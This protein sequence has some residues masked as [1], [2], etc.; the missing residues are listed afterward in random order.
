MMYSGSS[1]SLSFV[2]VLR[3]SR[4]LKIVKLFNG[5]EYAELV[6]TTMKKS[7]VALEIMA[8]MALLLVVFFGAVL[9][10]CEHGNFKVSTDNP[11]GVYLR[12]TIVGDGQEQ[13]SIFQSIAL[14]IYWCSITTT[15]VGTGDFAPTTPEG[16]AMASIA[17][18]AG[19]LVLAMPVGV[20]GNNF[21]E[22]YMK[23]VITR[24]KKRQFE[25]AELKIREN[26][27]HGKP[28]STSSPSAHAHTL[29]NSKM[30]RHSD[31]AF[32]CEPIDPFV[33]LRELVEYHRS[34]ECP[35]KRLSTEHLQFSARKSKV[36]ELLSVD[37]QK[38]IL[39]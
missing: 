31:V 12:P 34:S 15:T 33:L 2:R 39:V 29:A 32:E 38:E 10:T 8:F 22:E 27:A 19:L 13:L 9:Y 4:A 26:E 18:Y 5:E 17:A 6:I 11:S 1:T 20:I 35:P 24:K 25:E 14:G 21:V 7:S 37:S 16:R 23:L 3:L 36:E 28:T 30:R